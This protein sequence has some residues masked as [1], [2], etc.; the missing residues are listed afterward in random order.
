M[1]NLNQALLGKL[2]W[3]FLTQCNSLWAS[4][5]LAKY[6]R[7]LEAIQIH[8]SRIWRGIQSGVQNVILDEPLLG[9]ATSP[10]TDDQL[11]NTMR[12]YWHLGGLWRW[13]MLTPF[14]PADILLRLAVVGVLKN[15]SGLDT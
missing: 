7:S 6:V 2:S 1:T 10:I 8:P 12:D 4:V 11:D 14:L 5:L 13:D 9:K 15:E 3:R